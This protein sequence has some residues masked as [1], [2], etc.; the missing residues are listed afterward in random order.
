MMK[1]RQKCPHCGESVDFHDDFCPSCWS[2]RTKGKVLTE[3]Q[4]AACE[5]QLA[6]VNDKK[7]WQADLAVWQTR[8][9]IPAILM[10]LWCLFGVSLLLPP[11]LKYGA[12]QLE[13]AIS[14]LGAAIF[15]GGGYL[16]GGA[17][18]LHLACPLLIIACLVAM[19]HSGDYLLDV[20]QGDARLG[21]GSFFNVL[22]LIFCGTILVSAVKILRLK[23]PAA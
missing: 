5:K 7:R 19:F 11:F 1:P 20:F 16:V 2:H 17:R 23:G 22:R 18:A 21:K 4:I 14:F 15:A 9:L 3:E 8:L 13:I 10:T 12:G 6:A